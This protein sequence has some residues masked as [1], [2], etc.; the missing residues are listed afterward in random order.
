M[1]KACLSCASFV[2]DSDSQALLQKLG[3][4]SEDYGWCRGTGSPR[5]GCLVP[6]I[7]DACDKHTPKQTDKCPE[8]N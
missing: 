5:K 6:P 8:E 7:L 2:R 4:G 3:R 1:T